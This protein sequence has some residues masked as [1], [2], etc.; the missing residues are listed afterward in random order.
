MTPGMDRRTLLRATGVA[1]LAGLGGTLL[2]AAPAT[3]AVPGFPTFR[4]LGEP[5]DMANLKYNPT[6]ELIFPS[7]RH[8]AGRIANP[9]AAWYLY[10]APHNDPGGICLAYANTLTGTF[11]EYPNNP[12]IPNVW[13]GHYSVP[14][15][16][17]PHAYY[18][19]ADRHIYLYFHGDNTTTRVARSADGINFEY[20]GV[21]VT[22]AMMAA[23]VTEASYARVFD[24][25][26]QSGTRIM[27]LMGAQSGTRKIFIGWSDKLTSGWKVKPQ[28]LITP[29][30][31]E[32]GQLSGA[33]YWSRNGGGHV[34]Y[35]S[36]AGTM[37]VAD[38]GVGF[39]RERHLGVLHTPLSGAPDNGR[40]AAPSF[41]EDGGRLYMFYEGGQRDHTRIALARA[42]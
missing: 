29:A 35:H 34:V 31:G 4:H 15:V 10:Y 40:S 41:V 24:H 11:T 16:S 12:V 1:G 3:A 27:L 17:S 7:I 23:G 13:P 26:T 14:H 18:N 33:H 6:K 21:V 22:T 5:L 8:V 37:H 20:V 28:P 42:T 36:G 2:G 19:A 9:R 38:V 30:A 25:P 39:D 32:G